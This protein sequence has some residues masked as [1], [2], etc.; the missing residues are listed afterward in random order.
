M[1]SFLEKPRIP[2]AILAG[3]CLYLFFFNLGGF[4]LTDPDETFYAQTAKEMLQ[5]GEW[6]TPYL[7]GKPQFEKPALI[8]WLIEASYK[9]FGVNEFA[10]RL[11]SAA[12]GFA[13]VFGIYYLGLL[14]FSRRVGILSAFIMA[15]NVEYV[16]LARACVTDMAL[17]V[18]ILLGFLSFFLGYIKAKRY[19]Y[20]LSA[21]FFALAVLTKGPIAIILP[22]AALIVYLFLTK[23]LKAIFKIPLIECVLVFLAVAMPWYVLMHR[24]HGAQFINEFFGFRNVN[25]FLEAEHAIGSQWYYNIPIILGG[26][27]PW[28]VFLPAGLWRAFKKSTE[29]RVQSTE[30]KNSVFLLLWFAVVF[31]FFSVSSTKL[32]TYIFPCF[33]SLAMVTAVFWDD[34]LNNKPEPGCRRQMKTSFNVMVA[35]IVLGSFI[36]P[37]A[38]RYKYPVLSHDIFISTM[39]LVFGIIISAVAFMKKSYTAAFFLV[40]Y[41]L[42]IFLY[43]VSRLVLPELEPLESSKGVAVRLKTIMKPDE[44]VGCESNYLAGLAFYTDKVPVDLDKYH[45]QVNFIRSKGRMWG[46]MKEKNH[47]QIY[48]LDSKPYC[49]VPT[50]MVFKVGKRAVFTNDVPKGVKYIARRER[51]KW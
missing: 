22:I 4:A 41:A 24:A 47:I 33:M 14:L 9:A 29:C 26:F 5:R 7:Y 28:S 13:G 21:V 43:P 25:R 31:V 1:V 3:L 19:G 17:G 38:I 30:K 42:A 40:I 44:P 23:D 46:V 11:P 15:T 50:Y 45:D 27:F 18:F 8:Y 32:P 51:T 2:V 36:A 35:I 49:T 48:T 12:L 34:F 10:A 6:L 39:F 20:L 16:I 37:L